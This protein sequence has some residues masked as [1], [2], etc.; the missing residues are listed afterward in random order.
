MVREHLRAIPPDPREALAQP[1]RSTPDFEAQS[2]AH[3]YARELLEK[4]EAALSTGADPE[5]AFD[6]AMEDVK[7][8]MYTDGLSGETIRVSIDDV[9]E[10]MNADAELFAE[11]ERMTAHAARR[12]EE[13]EDAIQNAPSAEELDRRDRMMQLSVKRSRL[14]QSL[15]EIDADEQRRYFAGELPDA[16]PPE[17]YPGEFDSYEAAHDRA[18]REEVRRRARTFVLMGM[19]EKDALDAAEREV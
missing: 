12:M 9:V 10:T 6:D 18:R 4:Y 7:N 3:K 5:T 13:A 17:R 11:H 19:N 1:T 16:A 14:Q 2:Q 15:A 8:N